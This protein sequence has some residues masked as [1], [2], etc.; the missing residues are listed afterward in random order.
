[1]NNDPN[2]NDP[3]HNHFRK[4]YSDPLLGKIPNLILYHHC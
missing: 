3:I 4:Y 1:M 2:Q